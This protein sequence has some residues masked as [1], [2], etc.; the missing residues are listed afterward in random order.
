VLDKQP[1]DSSLELPGLGK[2]NVDP[3]TKQIKFDQIKT[4]NADNAASF[5]F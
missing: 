4:F 2:A 5:G 1:V 3:A